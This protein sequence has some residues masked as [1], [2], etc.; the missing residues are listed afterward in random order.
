MKNNK[1]ITSSVLASSICNLCYEK[2]DWF[3]KQWALESEQVNKPRL[4]WFSVIRTVEGIDLD[5]P[6]RG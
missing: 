1:K 4:H 2:E 3:Y 6:N 5:V